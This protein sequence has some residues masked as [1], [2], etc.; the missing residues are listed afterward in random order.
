[1]DTNQNQQI[2]TFVRGM[3][4]DTSDM[5]ISSDQ[6]R[7]A[8]N[9]RIT[10]N[11][12][13][14]DGEL[15][16]I[17][18]VVPTLYTG[19]FSNIINTTK[20]RN[21][22]IIIGVK[23]G[24]TGWSIYSFDKDQQELTDNDRIFG[25][26]EE[27]LESPL[28]LVTRWESDNNVKL[29]IAS[30]NES[31]LSINIKH[32]DGRGD[33]APKTLNYIGQ[34]S[35]VGVQQ[36][37]ITVEDGDGIFKSPVIQYAYRLYKLGGQS[38][39]VSPLSK[40]ICLNK[41]DYYESGYSKE[42][43]VTKKIT[44]N[45]DTNSI[46]E[47]LN[48]IQIFRLQY[49]ENGQEPIVDI[50]YDNDLQQQIIDQGQ[51]EKT[52]SVSEFIS[53]TNIQIKP[54]LIESKGDYLFAANIQ[55]DQNEIDSY[56]ENCSLTYTILNTPDSITRYTLDLNGTISQNKQNYGRS[57]RRGE[58]YRY[59]IVFY[60]PDG[61]KTSVMCITDAI[62]IPKTKYVN[63]ITTV[64]SSSG[65][66]EVNKVGI[67]FTVNIPNDVKD[68][69]A[70]YEIVRCL[71]SYNDSKILGQGIIGATFGINDTRLVSPFMSMQKIYYSHRIQEDD[72]PHTGNS[73]IITLATPEYLY[74][75]ENTKDIINQ[76][77]GNLQ[78][79]NIAT[80]NT[81]YTARTFNNNELT[82]YR[83]NEGAT[84]S[85]YENRWMIDGFSF[86]ENNMYNIKTGP[87][88]NVYTEG[89]IMTQRDVKMSHMFPT[90]DITESQTT[91]NGSK[92][93]DIYDHEFMTSPAYNSFSNEESVTI[94]DASYF[95]GQY[96]VVN[97]FATDFYK[98]GAYNN[99]ILSILQNPNYSDW[100]EYYISS[101]NTSILL[102]PYMYENLYNFIQNTT[103]FLPITVVDIRKK[104]TSQPYG[105]NSEFAKNNCVFYSFGNYKKLQNPTAVLDTNDEVISYTDT[106]DVFDGDCYICMFE[107][108]SSHCY[109]SDRYH[110]LMCPVVYTVPIES[111]I[112][113]TKKS[114]T[115][116]TN[117]ASALRQ[118]VQDDPVRIEYGQINYT[119]TKPAYYINNSY[120]SN[121]TAISFVPI[122]YTE[123]STDIYDTRIYYSNKKQNGE[124]IDSW[125]QFKPANFL[126]VD[127]RYGS[128]TNLRLFKDNLLFWQEHATGILSVNERTVIQDTNNTN[129]IL[130][131]GDV[132]QRFDYI[133]TIYGMRKNDMCETLSNDHAY[134][135]D[136]YNKELLQ[137][138]NGIQVTT[139]KKT[140]NVSNLVDNL[141]S[142]ENPKLLWDS[143]NKEVLF[144]ILKDVN[145]NY[146]TLTYSETIQQ[147][148]SVY[149]LPFDFSIPFDNVIYF[150]KNNK[151]YLKNNNINYNNAKSTVL[152]ISG[153]QENLNPLIKFVI[154]NK[155]TYNKTFDSQQFGGRFYSGSNI[156][157]DNIQDKH[158]IEGEHDNTPLNVLTFS[159]NTPLKQHSQTNGSNITNRE[160]NYKLDI[161]RDTIADY[162]GR[163][164]GKTMQCELKSSNNSTD[165]S[166]QYVITK[167]RQSWN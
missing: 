21:Y 143:K 7:Y 12:D 121:P 105:G 99:D 13:N 35:L 115:I 62:Y 113:L 91:I 65:Y 161:P 127:S 103:Y 158:L 108:L 26:C 1:M 50:I 138:T 135:F 59:G 46:P 156:V 162:G 126:D 107:Y 44:L 76:S 111:S 37:S 128:I 22:C 39:Q 57:L 142:S 132:L 166:L 61:K 129:I 116:Y 89:S 163:L 5:Y 101:G 137:Y 144:S 60:M 159:Y 140:K 80:Y 165:F 8:E 117:N 18:G 147:F 58:Y 71:R 6:Y 155:Y 92:I 28:S 11:T 41:N 153:Q 81:R 141:N 23:T 29:Y 33:N 42:E 167:F 77:T 14:N 15:H 16:L 31:I 114:G 73:Y 49:V 96:N 112:D 36:I 110:S 74:D 124:S 164:R 131:N 40:L 109:I 145:T 79:E 83:A 53:L 56:F 95:I 55:Y 17:D 93:Q 19:Y 125:Y 9:V 87:N 72:K 70:G 97:W 67:R 34:N 64:G 118:F 51:S 160:Y 123:I 139:L 20:I 120:L 100:I 4:T 47:N 75:R 94:R 48:R 84:F 3:D 69:C 10:T 146:K 119:Q 86:E 82:V 148:T 90:A 25:P 52:I 104:N 78:I 30:K 38:T 152:N 85:Q 150:I 157:D 136:Y 133:S 66:Y 154:N 98:D 63:N 45:V 151:I 130:G 43:N 134:W 32:N 2:N 88:Y 149:N 27:D 24:E 68:K 122:Q 54:Q 102:R 106:I